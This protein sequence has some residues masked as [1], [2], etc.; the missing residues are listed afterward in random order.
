M[1]TKT[2]RQVWTFGALAGIAVLGLTGCGGGGGGVSC[3]GAISTS[4]VLDQNGQEV[5]CADGDM[6]DIRVDT[7]AM[8]ATFDCSAH[9]GVTLSVDG[10][11]THDVSLVLY[12]VNGNVLSQTQNM[13]LY[14]PC[15]TTTPTPQVEFD[16]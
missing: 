2:K 4:W 14:V 13:Q 1:T 16:L 3:G 12:D 5:E 10:D 7:D 9:S 15:G 8:T 11:A 6:V